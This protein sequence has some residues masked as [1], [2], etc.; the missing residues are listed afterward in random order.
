MLGLVGNEFA[1]S[2]FSRCGVRKRH[3]ALT[4]EIL[5]QPLQARVQISEDLLLD[6]ALKAAGDLDCEPSEIGTVISATYFT[7]GG[8]TLAHRLVSELGL[9]P[10]TDKYHVVGIGCA[11]AVPLFKLAS[12][13]LLERPES[14]VLV[15]AADSTTGS[16][17]PAKPGDE[18]TKMVAASLF[19]DGC[20]A[21]VLTRDASVSGPAVLATRV[22]QIED[23]IGAVSFK[24]RADESHMHMGRDLPSIA[25]EG[26]GRLVDGFLAERGL[27]RER[28]AHWMI[29]PGGRGIVEAV[30]ESLALSRDQVQ[31]SY[32]V[33]ADYG[34]MG[35]PSSLYVLKAVSERNAPKPGDLGLMVTVGPGV[36]VGLMLLRW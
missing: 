22:H 3:F 17:T 10:S 25:R 28:I 18:K 34:N 21:A 30:E 4:P 29:H 14:R 5:A 26:A 8:P 9:S 31:T 35:T 20:A 6:M 16:L 32:D 19:S 2:V 7:L 23:T 12:Q 13:A 15:V 1:E 27:T 33:L 36:T 24:L 11:S